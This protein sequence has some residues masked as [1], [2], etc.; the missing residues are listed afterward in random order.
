[1]FIGERDAH[2]LSA[3]VAQRHM[4]QVI[5]RVRGILDPALEQAMARRLTAMLRRRQVVLPEGRDRDLA[6]SLIEG[7]LRAVAARLPEAAPVLA[8]A[9]RNAA[10]G[11]TLDFDFAFPDKAAVGKSGTTEATALRI[12]PGMKRV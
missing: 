11:I 1:M 6:R 3:H 10:S 7:M 9:A 12:T 2:A 4:V 8:D 5:A